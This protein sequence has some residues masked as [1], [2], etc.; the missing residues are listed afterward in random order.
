M[1]KILVT[2]ATGFIA[3][4][5]ILDLFD[6]GYDVRGTAR[7]ASKAKRL[8][9]ILTD[10]AGRPI[11]IELISADLGGDSGW[12]EAMDGVTY[13]HHV[14]SP[15]PPT[16][17]KSA[18]E[19]IEPARD[20]ALRVLT[21]AE[22]AGVKRVVMTSSIAAISAGWAGREPPM[23]DETFW[24]DMTQPDKVSFYSQSKTLAEKAAWDYVGKDSIDLELAVINPGA[25]LGPAMS[26]DVSTSL[27]MV[28]APMNRD[29]PAYPKLHQSVVDVRDVSKA[30]I[31]AMET[32][33]AAGERFIVCADTLWFKQVG[34][35]LAEAYP[36]RKMPSRELPT[37]LAK[38]PA[39]FNPQIKPIL[40]NLGNE[41]RYNNKK[42]REQLGVD[43]IPAKD[44]ILASAN[45]AVE[46]GLV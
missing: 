46:L 16:E 21:A 26:Q 20:G 23:F 40:P 27:S 6:K 15:F 36:D 5:L 12:A 14:A 4:Q 24:T 31:A 29:M 41:R 43:F 28:T 22:T 44:A 34:D 18:N 3:S 35:I 10:Y 30:H 45:S 13:V 33:D 2:G 32:A 9:K 17:P 38:I 39:N 8:N 7:D 11:D 25:V 19:L 42:T 1:S 37:W